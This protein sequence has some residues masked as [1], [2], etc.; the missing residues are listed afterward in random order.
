MCVG[1]MQ[2]FMAWARCMP[3]YMHG[4]MEHVY[5]SHVHHGVAHADMTAARHHNMHERPIIITILLIHTYA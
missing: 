5:T 1:L 3:M 4:Y 2:S